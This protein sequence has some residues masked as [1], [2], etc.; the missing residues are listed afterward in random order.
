MSVPLPPLL[1]TAVD[2]LFQGVW[3]KSLQAPESASHQ[4]GLKCLC[5]ASGQLLKQVLHPFLRKRK[6]KK[7]LKGRDLMVFSIFAPYHSKSL[8]MLL[9]LS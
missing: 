7:Q 3:E 9:L 4:L 5:Q 1:Q 6:K 8:Q 2:F